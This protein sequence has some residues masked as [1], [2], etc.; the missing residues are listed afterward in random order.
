MITRWAL[1]SLITSKLFAGITKPLE[2]TLG[3]FFFLQLFNLQSVGP[4]LQT[5]QK[6]LNIVMC[7]EY[8]LFNVVNVFSKI[9]GSEYIF[10]L[11]TACVHIVSVCL[12][13]YF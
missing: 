6:T 9:E 3:I 12:C 11:L 7:L 13:T 8:Y 2:E 10:I 1:K 4:Y 5:I